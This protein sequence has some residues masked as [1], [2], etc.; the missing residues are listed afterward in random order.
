MKLIYASIK[1]N[2]TNMI[3]V[4]FFSQTYDLQLNFYELFYVYK[5]MIP[6]SFKLNYISNFRKEKCSY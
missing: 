1:L 2:L 4:F 3:C 5:N 6:N